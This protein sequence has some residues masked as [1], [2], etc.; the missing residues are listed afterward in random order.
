MKDAFSCA[1]NETR[2]ENPRD[3]FKKV[4]QQSSDF[5]IERIKGRDTVAD[6]EW[7]QEGEFII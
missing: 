4:S 7:F 2:H 5:E 1:D 6:V 3:F